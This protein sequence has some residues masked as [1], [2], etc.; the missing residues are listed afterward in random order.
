MRDLRRIH[1]YF[2]LDSAKL[3]A[4]ALVSS[5]L[6]YC[7]SRLYGIADSDLIKL[8]QIQNRLAHLVTRSPPFTR[9]VPLRRSLHWLPAR[10]KIL[11]KVSLLTY[12][13][14]HEKHPAYL[15]SIFA[16]WLPSC[17]LT[18]KELVCQS[19][20]SRPT[21]VQDHLTLVPLLFRTT[22]RYLSVQPFQSLP[23]RHISRHISLTWPFPNRHQHTRWPVDVM[24]LFL[25]FSCWT[26]IR[27]LRATGF[28]GDIGAI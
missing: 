27:L 18:S 1:C 11:F 12:K 3:L 22:S 21:Q 8:Q 13:T 4:T 20:G 23:L 6:I 16:A 7:N 15:H 9:S 24:E 25:W 2:D 10:F 19:L 26:L 5:R 14:L 28:G 17:S